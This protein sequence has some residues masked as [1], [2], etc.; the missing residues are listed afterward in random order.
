MKILCQEIQ[1]ITQYSDR[2]LHDKEVGMLT[3]TPWHF[4]VL[5]RIKLIP[6]LFN[7]A[8]SSEEFE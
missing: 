6:R 4:Y 5:A 1:S 2:G 3:S 7:D 8:V